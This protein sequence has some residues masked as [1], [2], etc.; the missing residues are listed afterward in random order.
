MLSFDTSIF[1]WTDSVVVGGGG[2][3]GGQQNKFYRQ[4]LSLVYAWFLPWDFMPSA[5]PGTTSL[6]LIIQW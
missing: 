1:F 3:G 2:G 6:A 4:S 5:R